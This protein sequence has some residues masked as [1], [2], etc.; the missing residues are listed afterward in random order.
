MPELDSIFVTSLLSL[1]SRAKQIRDEPLMTL[2]HLVD[3]EWLGESWKKLRKGAAYGIDAVSASKYAEDLEANLDRLLYRMK[4]GHYQSQPVKRIYIAKRDG[5]KR[6]LG[7]PTVEDKIVQ[8]AINLLLKAIY[9]QEFLP[10]SYGFRENKNA[11][12][13]VEDVKE[14]IAQKKVSWVLEVDIASFFDIAKPL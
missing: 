1:A 13:A 12:Q 4:V 2:M 11:L 6:A 14:V 7:L 5:K 8:N 9:E 10:I 3:K